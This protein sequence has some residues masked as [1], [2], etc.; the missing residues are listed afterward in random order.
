M[1]RTLARAPSALVSARMPR[2]LPLPLLGFA[3]VSDHGEEAFMSG[4]E[5]AL[6][7]GRIAACIA[8]K[9]LLV[10]SHHLVLMF[11]DIADRRVDLGRV[12]VE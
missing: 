1:K 4:V 6:E 9:H 12:Q 2:I 10:I 5:L 8:G 7:L 11:F 3:A